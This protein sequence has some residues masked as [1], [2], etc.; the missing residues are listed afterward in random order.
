MCQRTEPHP[1]KILQ[2]AI[3]EIMERI[4]KLS[5]R[6]VFA[7]Q[8][9]PKNVLTI[10]HRQRIKGAHF[11]KHKSLVRYWMRANVAKNFSIISQVS[12]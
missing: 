10:S 1:F 9:F 5:K 3:C 2:Q 7:M 6:R 11:S 8:M 4:V 12:F